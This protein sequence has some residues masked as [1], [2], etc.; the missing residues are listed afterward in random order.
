MVLERDLLRKPNPLQRREGSPILHESTVCVSSVVDNH[1]QTK[2][3][4][5]LSLTAGRFWFRVSVADAP[6]SLTMLIGA[7]HAQHSLRPANQSGWN[8]LADWD[9]PTSAVTAPWV[10]YADA[11]LVIRCLFARSLPPRAASCV[12]IEHFCVRRA[13]LSGAL[14]LDDRCYRRIS[15]LK[16]TYDLKAIHLQ[17]RHTSLLLM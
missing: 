9:V 7:G 17:R 13:E 5:H 16:S 14:A 3:R 15:D 11:S 10:G 2:C 12:T 4:N 1:P 8:E 6:C